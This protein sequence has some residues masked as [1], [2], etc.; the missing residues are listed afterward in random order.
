MHGPRRVVT[1]ALYRHPAGTELRVYLGPETSDD[2]LN[3][4]VERFDIRVLE[5]RAAALRAILVEKGWRD[6]E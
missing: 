5:E 2:L 1:A 4:Q 6:A 3:S